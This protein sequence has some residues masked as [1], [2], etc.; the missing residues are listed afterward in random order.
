MAKKAVK[1][2]AFRNPSAAAAALCHMDSMKGHIF[3]EITKRA[4]KEVVKFSKKPTCLLKS[5]S[6][7][8]VVSLSTAKLYQQLCGG[9]P[10]LILFLAA[11]CKSGQPK[12]VGKS[13][14]QRPDS[15]DMNQEL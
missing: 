3:L 11:I 10:Y 1:N 12:A 14:L 9:C 6:T 5:N 8:S 2:I 4:T 7:N 13:I 15:L